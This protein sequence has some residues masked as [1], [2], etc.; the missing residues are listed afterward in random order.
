L[1][2]RRDQSGWVSTWG[3]SVP[4]GEVPGRFACNSVVGRDFSRQPQYLGK[5]KETAGSLDAPF[6]DTILLRVGVEEIAL[7]LKRGG[8]ERVIGV[9][10]MGS[11]S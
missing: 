7:P 11:D 4:F 10:V 3:E 8:T 2:E 9:G 6:S 5:T 1:R